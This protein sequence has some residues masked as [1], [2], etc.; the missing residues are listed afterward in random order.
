MGR[1]DNAIVLTRAAWS[2]LRRD[3]EL[4]VIPV[5]T[6][7]AALVTFAFFSAP[8]W[9]LLADDFGTGTAS[10]GV[11]TGVGI[12]GDPLGDGDGAGFSIGVAEAVFF[13]LATVAAGWVSTIGQAAVIAGAG[14]R[15]N[16]GDPTLRS[17]VAR[18]TDHSVWLLGWALLAAVI[19][20]VVR[21]VEERLGLLGR[22]FSFAASVAFSIVSFLTLPV[23][24]FESVGPIRALRR[25]TTLVRTTWGEQLAFNLGS[26]VVGVL[27]ALPGL[28]VGALAIASGVLA[29]QV[30]G[31]GVA[32]AW[33][34]AVAAVFAALGGVFKAALYRHATGQPLPEEFDAATVGRAFVAR[35]S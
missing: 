20:L 18:A 3:R 16:G 31:A 13:G 14:E 30:I 5:L 12:G 6:A 26:G 9:L 19:N 34:L 24:V 25:S 10:T 7:V 28:A 8:A 27:C 11:D 29:V 1:I 35:R 2:V 15:M 4:V 33:V 21:T 22:L 23:I 32:I 17:S